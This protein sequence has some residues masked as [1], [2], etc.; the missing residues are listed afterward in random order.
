MKI[1]VFILI[2]VLL[3]S[4]NTAFGQVDNNDTQVWNQNSIEFSLDKDN[5]KLSGLILTDLRLTKDISKLTDKRIGFGVRYKATDNITVQSSYIFRSDT[6]LAN[7]NRYEHHFLFDVTPNK[8]FKNFSLDNRSRLEHRIKTAGRND[9]TYYRNR[10]RIRIPVK[11]KDKIIFTPFVWNDTWF[12]LHKGRVLRND[13]SAGIN[14]RLN[15]NVAADF[16]YLYR[17]N[18]QSGT[19]NE[20]VIGVNFN[21]SIK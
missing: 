10:T 13:A 4:I 9:D 18:I 2:A 14:R 21:F 3:L 8:N 16:Y 19:K 12:D 17:R 15:K 7:N 5:E 11:S 1:Y 20:N 6:A